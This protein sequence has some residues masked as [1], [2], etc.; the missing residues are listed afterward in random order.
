MN[1]SLG[2][3]TMTGLFLVVREEL[4]WPQAG[5]TYPPA[6]Q[7]ATVAARPSVV[8]DLLVLGSTC[9][10]PQ[11][12]VQGVTG[13]RVGDSLQLFSE[14]RGGLGQGSRSAHRYAALSDRVL[15]RQIH[16][17]Q[18]TL[19]WLE[20]YSRSML[21]DNRHLSFTSSVSSNSYC[22]PLDGS[23]M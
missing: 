10:R 23:R 15:K 7:D 8:D 18:A 1:L 11:L 2:V 16:Y 22:T 19:R 3:A 20:M 13:Q 4:R 12:Q 21:R 17:Y 5:L 14:G 9:H 6:E